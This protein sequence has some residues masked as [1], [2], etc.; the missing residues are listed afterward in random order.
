M[1]QPSSHDHRSI[2]ASG[3]LTGANAKRSNPRDARDIELHG[4]EPHHH[5]DR[6]DRLRPLH[7]V[8]DRR[9]RC[10]EFDGDV[11]RCRGPHRRRRHPDRGGLRVPRSVSGRRRGHLDDP[12]GHHRRGVSPARSG[13]AR[14]RHVVGAPGRVRL[15]DGRFQ[16]RLAGVHHAFDRRSD[17]R[18]RGGCHRNRGRPLVGR[19]DD[20]GEL[21]RH[22]RPRRSHLLSA[23]A[24]RAAAD[25]QQGRTGMC[26]RAAM[27]PCTSS[28][29]C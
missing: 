12:Q 2:S 14:H 7:G 26:T 3:R 28:P 24:E 9:Q 15:A 16:I 11:G 17:H 27:C 10:R 5:S 25:I 1:C 19:G 13:P 23:G 22:S 4:Y 20:C 18:I 8:G 21:G 29:R 6:G